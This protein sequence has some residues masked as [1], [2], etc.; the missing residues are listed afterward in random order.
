MALVGRYLSFTE[1]I[2]PEAVDLREAIA[3]LSSPK[4]IGMKIT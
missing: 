3:A 2:L 4:V 1:E